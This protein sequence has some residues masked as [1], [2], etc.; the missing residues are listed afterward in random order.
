MYIIRIV[1]IPNGEAPLEV[2]EAWVGLELPFLYICNESR[3]CR[4][5]DSGL[6][7]DNPRPLVWAV[8]EKEALETLRSKSPSAAEWFT[9]RGYPYPRTVFTFGIEEAVLVECNPFSRN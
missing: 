3:N 7:V 9:I 2:R 6:P 8:P 5:A 1:K 4:G